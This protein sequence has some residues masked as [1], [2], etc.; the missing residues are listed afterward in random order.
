MAT[1][2]RTG[3]SAGYPWDGRNK[4][5]LLSNTVSLADTNSVA[6]DTLQVLDIPANTH[7][8][9]VYVRVT[10]IEDSA[11]TATVG[12]GTDP[13]G[14]DNSVNFASAGYYTGMSDTDP[15]TDGEANSLTAPSGKIYTAA[16][17]IDLVMSAAA[18]DTAVFTV[19]ALCIDL[20]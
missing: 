20:N 12:D 6:S 9:N 17:T 2:D 14:W 5:F 4:I 8:L 19:Y 13:N 10:T 18:G 16:D 11:L 3:G 1:V 7:V 15:Y